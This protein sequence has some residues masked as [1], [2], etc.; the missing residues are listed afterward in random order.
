MSYPKKQYGDYGGSEF[1]TKIPSYIYE[2]NEYRWGPLET[3]L[4]RF[5]YYGDLTDLK[6]E[7]STPQM[8][9]YRYD[10]LKFSGIDDIL[11]YDNLYN[12]WSDDLGMT[13]LKSEWDVYKK[14]PATAPYFRY[15]RYDPVQYRTWPSKSNTVN[16]GIGKRNMTLHAMAQYQSNMFLRNFA[17]I[18][19]ILIVGYIVYASKTKTLE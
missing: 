15:D 5:G 14:D 3:Q 10:G 1:Y 16:S 4:E 18:I 12:Y 17:I 6:D 2:P 8:K 11:F 7:L 13:K 9:N 19:I